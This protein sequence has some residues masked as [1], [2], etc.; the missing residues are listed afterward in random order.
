MSGLVVQRK[1][2]FRPLTSVFDCPKRT[3]DVFPTQ[4][5]RADFFRC[6]ARWSGLGND[7]LLELCS[8]SRHRLKFAK[9]RSMG[10]SAADRIAN[11]GVNRQV[12]VGAVR[13]ERIGAANSKFIASLPPAMLAD[14]N[15][16]IE[17]FAETRPGSHSASRGAHVNPVAVLDSASCGSCRIQFDLRV[18]C[19]LAQTRQ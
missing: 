13:T 3:F 19:A 12:E 7:S 18:Q 10:R 17:C 5:G 8:R 11:R 15:A 6:S 4:V 1:S 2:D 14:D 16:W 9:I